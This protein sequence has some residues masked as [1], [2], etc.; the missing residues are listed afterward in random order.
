MIFGRV[1]LMSFV[2]DFLGDGREFEGP[3]TGYE[4]EFELEVD[5][6]LG[7]GVEFEGPAE[8][9][10]PTPPRLSSPACD[11]RVLRGLEVGGATVSRRS[12]RDLNC[13]RRKRLEWC[14]R[15]RWIEQR[16]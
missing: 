10:G 5:L 11:E 14:T 6:G 13:S 12:W 15:T 16:G 3:A 9:D 2:G 4:V 7:L 8:E 1:I